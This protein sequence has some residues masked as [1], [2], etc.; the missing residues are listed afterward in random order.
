MPLATSDIVKQDIVYRKISN[1][2]AKFKVEVEEAEDGCSN[3]TINADFDFTSR[4]YRYHTYGFK[5]FLKNYGALKSTIYPIFLHIFPLLALV[6]FYKLAGII[7][8][9]YDREA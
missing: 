9:K 8:R 2:N 6:F 3:T 7:Q 4:E 1:L 5:D